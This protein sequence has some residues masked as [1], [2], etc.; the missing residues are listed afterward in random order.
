MYYK[1]T[2]LN[3]NLFLTLMEYSR[4][5]HDTQTERPTFTAEIIN[6]VLFSFRIQRYTYI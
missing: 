6:T 1:T 4:L 2:K 3:V 5:A